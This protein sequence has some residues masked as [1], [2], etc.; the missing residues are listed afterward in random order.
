MMLVIGRNDA[1]GI[2]GH[3][4]VTNPKWFNA[5]WR[6]ADGPGNQQAV[7]GH[8]L[9]QRPDLAIAAIQGKWDGRFG[10]N[11][12]IRGRTPRRAGAVCQA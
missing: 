11:H 8:P 6:C 2:Q 4:A 12:H 9:H 3:K 10:P 1:L 7:F 5:R